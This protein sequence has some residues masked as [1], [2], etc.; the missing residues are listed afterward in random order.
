MKENYIT[1]PEIRQAIAVIIRQVQSV[2]FQQEIRDIRKHG[3]VSLKSK[4]LN[5]S[6]FLD[7]EEIL[8]VGGRLHHAEI[9]SD[10]KHPIILPHNHRLTELLIEHAHILTFHG[11]ARVTMSCIRQKYWIIGGNNEKTTSPVCGMQE[12]K[13]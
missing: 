1:L 6:P 10:Q 7:E 8:R 3:R 4:I 13:S 12:T 2:V 5:L 9:S 11:G